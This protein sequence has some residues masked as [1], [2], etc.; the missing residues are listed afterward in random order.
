MA[1][2]LIQ[3]AYTSEAWA[4]LVKNPEDRT[5]VVRAALESLGGKLEALY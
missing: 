1:H 3:G 2:Y 4:G 5:A